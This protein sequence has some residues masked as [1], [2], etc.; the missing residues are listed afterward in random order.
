[1][2]TPDYL[3]PTSLKLFEADKD[4]FYLRY[5]ADNRPPRDP[6]TQPMAAGSAFDAFCKSF[7]YYRLFGHYGPDNQYE[8]DAIFESQVEAHNRDWA[9]RAGEN[10]FALYKKSGALADLMGELNTSASDPR[11]E[12]A[13][14]DTIHGNSGA[15][16]LLGKPDIFF[17]ND[18]GCRVLLD[19]KVNGYCGKS[20]TSP[21]PGYVN[22]RDGW[23]PSERKPSPRNR[24]PHKDCSPVSFRGIRINDRISMEYVNGDW[25]AQTTTYA[26][27]LGEDI[28]SD[29][30][31]VG[32]EQLCGVPT[33]KDDP[34][35]RC[36]SHRCR[37]SNDYQINLHSRY[38][39]AWTLIKSGN[40]FP[41]MGENTGRI[42]QDDL[43]NMANTLANADPN[44]F[45]AVSARMS[46][47]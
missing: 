31:V 9:R 1:M 25:A 20:M 28:G 32:I 26:W 17:I 15:V 24:L 8:R 44:S 41:E 45:E 29:G 30:L 43:E 18:Q 22:C 33:D 23:L 47:R 21:Q 13:V 37:V 40:I 39:H 7:L 10:L 4:A 2:R 12:F 3:S 46:R 5:L 14:Q 27:L 34:L 6:Q 35:V 16:P 42:H 36:A 38:V 19:W 11:F